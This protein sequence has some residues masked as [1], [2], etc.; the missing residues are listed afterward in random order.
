MHVGEMVGDQMLDLLAAE[1]VE[2]D[3]Q[4]SGLFERDHVDKY[5]EQAVRGGG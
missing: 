2:F 5:G 1:V 3:S 4:R